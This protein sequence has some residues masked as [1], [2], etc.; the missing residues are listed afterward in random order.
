MSEAEIIEVF[1]PR[2]LYGRMIASVAT[3]VYQG[4]GRFAPVYGK[5]VLDDSETHIKSRM[6]H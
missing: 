5:D 6:R 2:Q 1:Q 3:L 4:V